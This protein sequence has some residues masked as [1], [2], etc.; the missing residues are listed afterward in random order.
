M[1]SRGQAEIVKPICSGDIIKVFQAHDEHSLSFDSNY[2][3][4][5]FLWHQ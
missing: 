2:L 4:E 3:F 5:S 1:G